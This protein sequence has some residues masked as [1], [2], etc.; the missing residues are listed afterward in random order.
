[1]V[2][3]RYYLSP[4]IGTGVRGDPYRAKAADYGLP[5][6]AVIPSDVDGAPLFVWTVAFV[7]AP[8]HAPLLADATLIPLPS[9]AL[10]ARW[11]TAPVQ[12]RNRLLT[13]LAA[14][15][16]NVS[17]ITG[18][19]NLRDVLRMIGLAL[20]AGFDERGFWSGTPE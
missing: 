20:S 1:M 18:T 15:G 8:D 5:H 6:V 7:N 3:I 14:R 11:S 12:E 9:V 4:V 17:A 2:M 16:V 19:S 10:D 13:A